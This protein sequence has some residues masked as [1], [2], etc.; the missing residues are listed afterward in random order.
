MFRSVKY[1]LLLAMLPVVVAITGAA[2]DVSSTASEIVSCEFNKLGFSHPRQLTQ[3][4][5][6]NI[7]CQQ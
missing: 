4:R 1:L 3:Y 2:W 6:I 7:T 5:F